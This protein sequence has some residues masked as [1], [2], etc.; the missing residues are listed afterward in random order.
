MKCAN[1]GGE[2]TLR[3]GALVLDSLSLGS[4]TLN[5]VYFRKCDGCG[6]TILPPDTWEAADREEGRLLDETLT[7]LPVKDYILA[8]SAA[9]KLGISRQALHKHRRISKGFIYSIVI[10][11]LRFYHRGSL[12]KYLE[13]GDGRFSLIEYRKESAKVKDQPVLVI[14]QNNIKLGEMASSSGPAAVQYSNILYLRTVRTAPLLSERHF[15]NSKE[16]CNA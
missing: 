4:Y 3:H 5:D 6:E 9:R 11:G 13:S 2:L 7:S 14:P 16:A 8:A 15:F 1:C 10:D 12:E